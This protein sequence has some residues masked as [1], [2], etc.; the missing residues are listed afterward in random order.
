LFIPEN[1]KIMRKFGIFLLA[2][3]FITN[4]NSQTSSTSA[5]SDNINT[6]KKEILN[7]DVN[8]K[9]QW[10]GPNRDGIYEETGLLKKWPDGGPKLLWHY[11]QLGDGHSSAAVTGNAIYITGTDAA[12]EQGFVIAFQNDGQIIWKKN[13]GKEWLESYDGVRSSPLIDGEN[14]YI[15]SALGVLVCMNAQNGE[16]KWKVD[17]F[18]DFKGKNLTWGITENL[19][20]DGDKLF[21]IPG[22]EK[23][24]VLALNKN[25][26]ELIWKCAGNGEISAY[27]SPLVI[28][29]KGKKIFVGMTASSILGI[30]AET[31][32]M[33]W[34]VHQPNQY[35]VHANTP[36][37][38]DGFLFCVSG[39][40]KG[41]VMLKLSD[42]GTSVTE[43]WRDEKMDN[44]MG[45]FVVIDGIIYGSGDYNKKW[46]GIDWETGKKLF[47]SDM[48]TQGNIIFADGLLY[49][50]D[51]KGKVAL[52][53]PLKDSY[54]LI[55]SFEVP[56]GEKQHWAHSVIHNKRLF[57]RHGSSLMVYDISAN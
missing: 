36:I 10:R 25:T 32:K 34:S 45:G 51:Q 8:Q 4:C 55:S 6:S 9:A 31:G 16:Q 38:R 18:N 23:D 21:C 3:L 30:D 42:D 22:G 12:T 5:T 37:Y 52:A 1:N 41:S 15:M 11:D 54:R 39:Y 29:H 2:I 27:N 20:I 48:M 40:G 43:M 26:G 35:S 13:Y 50:Y 19:V 44:R 57:I 28:N 46:F 14:L 49:C 7:F 56:Y 17:V 33:L 24:N 47:E 53:E